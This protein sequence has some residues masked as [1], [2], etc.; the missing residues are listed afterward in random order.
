MS[1]ESL[2]C[3]KNFR[4]CDDMGSENPTRQEQ[5]LNIKAALT[6]Q[7]CISSLFTLNYILFPRVYNQQIVVIALNYQ[8]I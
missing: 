1:N 4:T 2:T 6:E 7:K 5:K 8:Y 3:V